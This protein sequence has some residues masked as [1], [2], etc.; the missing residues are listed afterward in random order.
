[1]KSGVAEHGLFID[2]LDAHFCVDKRAGAI[3]G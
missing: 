3:L 2:I 1:M